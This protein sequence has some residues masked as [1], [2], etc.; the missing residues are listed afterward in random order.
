MTYRRS[1]FCAA[2]LAV[3]LVLAFRSAP[4]LGAQPAPRA[5]LIRLL[6][7]NV[8][9]LPEGISRSRPETNIPRIS[10]LL[11]PFDLVLIQEDFAYPREL[12]SAAPHAHRTEPHRPGRA[13]LDHGDGLTFFSRWPLRDVT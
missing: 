7:Y 4:P 1:L 8:A 6:T 3:G 11:H 13:L 12:R 9:G 2:L 5:G 10:A